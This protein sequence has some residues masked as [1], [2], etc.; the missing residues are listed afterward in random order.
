MTNPTDLTKQELMVVLALLQDESDVLL[1]IRR[2]N[3]E[4]IELLHIIEPLI[5]KV[6]MILFRM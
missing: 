2:P 3:A 1:K 5:Q 4:T 6:E